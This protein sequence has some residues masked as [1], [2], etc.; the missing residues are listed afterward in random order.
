MLRERAGLTVQDLGAPIDVFWMRLSRRPD[1]SVEMLGR[2]DA[3]GVLVMLN[4]GD[5]PIASASCA[6]STTSSC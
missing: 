4:R 6:A 3:G 1:D 5:S 2:I